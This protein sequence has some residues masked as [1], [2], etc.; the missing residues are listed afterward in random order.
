VPY[1]SGLEEIQV[2]REAT[3]GTDLATTSK[4]LCTSFDVKPMSE[5][6]VPATLRGLMQRNRGFETVTKHSVEI[7]IEGPVSFENGLIMLLCSNLINVASPSGLSPYT[8]AFVK[9]PAVLPTPATLTLERKEYDGTTAIGQAWHYCVVDELTI[10]FADGQPLMFKAHLFGRK[11]QTETLTPA[12]TLPTPEIPVTA[13]ATAYIDTTFAGLGGTA[14]ANQVLGASLTMKN[15]AKPIW[16]LEARADLDFTTIGFD[17]AEIQNNLSITCLLGAQYAT[18]KAAALAQTLRAIQLK[19]LG[20][21]SRSLT[22]GGNYK[23]KTPDITSFGEQDGQ[24]IVTLDLEESAD[25][26]NLFTCTVINL[27][28]ALA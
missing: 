14:V 19:V 23:Y 20:T 10:T 6:Y 12:I 2:A 18:E 21:S 8:W 9:N 15:G 3:A 1:P 24:R 25:G 4:L 26:T 16:T 11:T 28:S 7:D 22:L 27:L 17:V 13:S 5:R